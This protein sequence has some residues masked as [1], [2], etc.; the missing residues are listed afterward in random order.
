M[1]QKTLRIA[2]TG[3]TGV[4][5]RTIRQSFPNHDWHIYNGDITNEILVDRW[6]K[7]LKDI[8]VILHFA[9]VV[10]LSCVEENPDYSYQVN[11]T[12][13]RNV[14]N[15]ICK[16]EG[17]KKAWFF[18]ASTSQVYDLSKN[19]GKLSENSKVVSSTLLYGKQKLESENLVIDIATNNAIK[20]CIGRIF[21]YSSPIQSKKFVIPNLVRRMK[22]AANNSSLSIQGAENIRD[23]LSAEIVVKIIMK[24]AEKRNEGIIN[25][26]SGK[27]TKIQDIAKQI[28]THLQRDDVS[29]EFQQSTNPTTMIADVTNLDRCGINHDISTDDLIRFCIEG[30]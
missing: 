28:Q 3:A 6:A 14:L 26:A 1:N 20:F 11:C 25:I 8:D 13:V 27:G 4:L 10:A 9:G 7:S 29:L 21:S 19:T 17:L 30:L 24:L 18:Y 15:S 5:G 23:F 16:N 2:I 22:Y 12:G